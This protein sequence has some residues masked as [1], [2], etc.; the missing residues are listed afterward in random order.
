[1]HHLRIMSTSLCRSIT[2]RRRAERDHPC[3]GIE[4][5][6]QGIS[7]QLIGE[8]A[9]LSGKIYS[10]FQMFATGQQ[11]LEKLRYIHRNPVR[12]GLM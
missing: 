1:M 10:P 12:R 9:H 8:A 11:F 2:R 7:R 3:G 6:E 4:E 5:A